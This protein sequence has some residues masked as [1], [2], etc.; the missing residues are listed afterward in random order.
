[1]HFYP[2]H[3]ARLR[4][5]LSLA[6]VCIAPWCAPA[7]AQDGITWAVTHFP[8]FQIRSGAH[9]GT[10]SF[11]G[12]LQTMMT[13]LPEYKHQ[14]SLMS[15]TRRDE[16]LREGHDI[17]T[18]SIFRNAAREKIWEFSKPA[19][20]HLDNRLVFLKENAARFGGGQVD[21]E[22]LFKRR[23]V[24]GGI[25]AGRSYAPAVDPLIASHK[26]APNLV[27]RSMPIEQFFEMLLNKNVDYL[28]LFAHETTFLADKFGVPQ[29]QFANL[30]IAGVPPYIY[31][32]VAC[33]KNAWGKAVIGKVNAVLDQQLATPEYRQFSE[34]WYEDDDKARVRRFYPQMLKDGR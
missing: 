7:C 9:Q 34:R 23:D 30:R 4:R 31:T 5:L 25:L 28:L 6:A 14:V 21:L 19:L 32:H 16:E 33:S 13:R 27:I 8:P 29:S 20:L 15:V 12:L 18:P 26:D 3:A 2:F 24:T 1:M 11:D 22:A 10:G 17:C